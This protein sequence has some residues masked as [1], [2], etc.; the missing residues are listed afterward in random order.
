[1]KAIKE[2]RAPD[3]RALRNGGRVMAIGATSAIVERWRKKRRVASASSPMTR[4]LPPPQRP[5]RRSERS[6][7][8]GPVWA[9]PCAAARRMAPKAACGALASG[10]RRQARVS[11]EPATG[12]L[13]SPHR[14]QSAA[15]RLS[16]LA[17]GHRGALDSVGLFEIPAGSVDIDI[18]I[19]GPDSL[20]L[21]LGP[22]ALSVLID[23]LR[24]DISIPV[25]GLSPSVDNV[26][27]Q[28][29]YAKAGFRKR[30]EYDAPGLG[31]LALMIMRLDR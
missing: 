27:A 2:L 24:S 23:A 22:K 11:L 17:K 31:R 1:M 9:R 30:R 25:L 3:K 5:D 29:A 8:A 7:F 18:L 21:G 6:R 26:A 4:L 13:A 14:L 20:G 19:G 10:C 28:R 16:A 12:R 15:D